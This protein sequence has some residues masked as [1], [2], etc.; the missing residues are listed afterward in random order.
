MTRGWRSE[1]TTKG[2]EGGVM[3]GHDSG[4]TRGNTT[5]SRCNEMMRDERVG[6]RENAE[7]TRGQGDKRTR[8]R[9]EERRPNT[10]WRHETTRGWCNKRMTDERRY[11]NQPAQWENERAVRRENGAM[12]G[13]STTSTGRNFKEKGEEMKCNDEVRWHPRCAIWEGIKSKVWWLTSLVL[14]SPKLGFS[15]EGECIRKWTI[16]V[17]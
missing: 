8:L 4:A 7:R 17:W 14:F 13:N 12:T 2:W 15:T 16:Q 11:V 10:S 6:Q 3:T 5:I 9:H 1:R